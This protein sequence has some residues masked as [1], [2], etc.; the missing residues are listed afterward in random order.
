MDMKKILL[1]LT[2]ALVAICLPV[3]A[4]AYSEEMAQL[5]EMLN[6]ELTQ[7]NSVQS[8]K[9]DGTNMIFTLNVKGQLSADEINL[10]SLVL[11][12]PE[13]KAMIVPQI[14][15][16]LGGDDDAKLFFQVLQ[17]ANT[18]LEL[19]LDAGEKVFTFNLEPGDLL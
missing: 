19:R 16:M 5:A 18:G 13:G 10:M 3:Q 2:M 14:K 8:V 12:T 4:S 15:Q 11:G 17:S 1:G 9:Y 7:D 6:K